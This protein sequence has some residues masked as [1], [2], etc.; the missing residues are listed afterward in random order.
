M[1][2]LLS[3]NH[4]IYKSFGDGWEVKGVFQNLTSRCAIEM[5]TRQYNRKFTK[6]H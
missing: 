2:Q 5:K 3:T 4:E 1:N 6:D